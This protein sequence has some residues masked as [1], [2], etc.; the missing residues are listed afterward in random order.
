MSGVPLSFLSILISATFVFKPKFSS[1][2]FH[3][4]V[5]ATEADS[6]GFNNF[7]DNAFVVTTLLETF[8]HCVFSCAMNSNPS[9]I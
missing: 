3:F 8:V 7:S 1:P 9:G 4:N 5:I 6:P 2:F